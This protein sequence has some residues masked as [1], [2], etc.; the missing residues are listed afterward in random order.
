MSDGILVLPLAFAHVGFNLGFDAEPLYVGAVILGS[1][2]G[3]KFSLLLS[4]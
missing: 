2:T 4:I 1:I 3:I